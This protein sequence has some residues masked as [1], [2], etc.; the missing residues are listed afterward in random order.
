MATRIRDI[1]GR[2]WSHHHRK[3]INARYVSHLRT[4]VSLDSSGF[5]VTL[6]LLDS[7]D[8]SVK[9]SSVHQTE[10][11]RSNDRLFQRRANFPDFIDSGRVA[12]E[13]Y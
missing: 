11:Y 5:Q 7:N 4:I 1:H 8:E 13:L 9:S 6:E 3:E 10:A 2:I 12:G